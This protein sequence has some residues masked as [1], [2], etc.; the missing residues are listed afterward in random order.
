MQVSYS[1]DS[2]GVGFDDERLVANAGL[3]AP[4]TLAGRLGLCELLDDTVDLGDV[5]GHANVGA[6]AMTIIHSVLAGA[7]SIDDCEVLRA[8]A[9]SA[10]LGHAVAAPSTLGTFLRGFSWAHTR[11]L[12]AVSKVMLGRAWAAGAGPDDHE[13]SFTIDMDSSIHETYGTKKE[14]GARFTY[15][16]V[17]GY[18]PLYAT[19]ADT[20]EVLHA[21]LRSGNANTARGAAGFLAET[22]SRVRA[23]EVTGPLSLRA[24]SGFYST[25]VVDACRKA[26][27]RFSITAKLYKGL[28]GAIS[29]IP[30][31]QWQPIPYFLEDGAD[32][33]V[34]PWQAFGP[35]GTACRLV[36]RRVKPTPGSQLALIATYS[37]H[38][39]ITDMPGDAVALDGWHR[40]HAVVENAIRDLKYGAGLN[41]LPSGRFGA[42]AAWLAL[43]VMAHNMSRWVA[44]IGGLDIVP[45]TTTDSTPTDTPATDSSPADSSPAAAGADLPAA[46]RRRTR[47]KPGERKTFIAT[48]T[49]RRRYL[50]IPGRLASSARKL[51]VHLPA[52]WPWAEQFNS[53]LEALRGV[54]AVT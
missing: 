37:Y 30:E 18:H 19:A 10:V 41:H 49:L 15:T 36:V 22:F 34:I 44:R 29:K 52:R 39:F 26:D 23:T 42:N 14:G 24:D 28:L 33:A 25:A 6:K 46:R 40:N 43:N 13:A 51:T 32:V 31:A 48:D 45:A 11:Q 53:M 54:P 7:D 4:A 27:V 35:E 3:I 2:V 9:T 5:A 20:G 1:L 16:K 50:A 38:A 8:G 17:R 12:D 21:R 47:R